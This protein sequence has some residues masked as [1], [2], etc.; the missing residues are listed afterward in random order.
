MGKKLDASP[1][2]AASKFQAMVKSGKSS[3]DMDAVLK[4]WKSM[5][6]DERGEMANGMVALL[7]QPAN[8]AG[9][10]FS[11]A[12]FMRNYADMAPEAK[13]LIFGGA[14]KETRKQLDSFAKMMGDLNA[15]NATR[16]TSGT[17]LS[18][19]SLA[20]LQLGGLLG[21]GAH[22]AGAHGAARLFNHP[23][24]LRWMQGWEKMVQGAAKRGTP[25][26]AGAVKTQAGLLEKLAATEPALAQD[27]LGLRD[28]ALASYEK[29]KEAAGGGEQ[30][31]QPK[32]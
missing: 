30:G 18:I 25:P 4:T 21:F 2:E 27:I 14:D 26:T 9:R 28:A 1:E 5:P 15:N 29:A 32:Q 19:M 7:G 24:T 12:T 23:A 8:S 22:A 20:S 6:K 16:N 10:E 3:G 11:P 13:N 31:D 17:A